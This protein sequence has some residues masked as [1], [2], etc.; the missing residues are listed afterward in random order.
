M[1]TG[2]VTIEYIENVCVWL[3]PQWC[4]FLSKADNFAFLVALC[5]SLCL[6]AFSIEQE[7]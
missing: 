6:K 7:V 2:Y 1:P 3:K 4:I 5:P